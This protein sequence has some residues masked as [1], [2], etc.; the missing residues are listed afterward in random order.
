MGESGEISVGGAKWRKGY[1]GGYQM[2]GS[3]TQDAM[4]CCFIHFVI[5]METSLLLINFWLERLTIT[6]KCSAYA[7]VLLFWF[8]CFK[9]HEN[10][11]RNL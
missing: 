6:H 1:R 9:S 10:I 3:N 7:V 5:F 2:G 11:F 8:Y 4:Q